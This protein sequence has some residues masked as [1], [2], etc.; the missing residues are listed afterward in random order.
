[1]AYPETL[2]ELTNYPKA[3]SHA[4][5]GGGGDLSLKTVNIA[6]ESQLDLEVTVGGAII[7][8][9]YGIITVSAGET[10]PIK[11]IEPAQI[12]PAIEWNLLGG[13]S[14]A[15]YNISS[16][17]DAISDTPDGTAFSISIGADAADNATITFTD[18]IG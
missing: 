13:C 15:D 4:G 12:M 5:A 17:D 11:Y 6:N 9:K 8:G 2:S 7:D 18:S 14:S 3:L 10:V 16:E 1:M